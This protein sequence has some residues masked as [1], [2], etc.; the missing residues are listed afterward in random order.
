MGRSASDRRPSA[1]L[2]RHRHGGEPDRHATGKSSRSLRDIA[3]IVS[4]CWSS[5]PPASI[6]ERYRAL[7]RR[8]LLLTLSPLATTTG[9]TAPSCDRRRSAGRIDVAIVGGSIIGVA[10]ALTLA[11]TQRFASHCSRRGIIAGEQSSRNWGWVRVNGRDR[12]IPLMLRASELWES[13]DE[14]VGG[15]TGYRRCGIVYRGA[16]AP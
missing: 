8:G 15:D 11:R 14:R 13:M 7:D 6:A 9:P 5:P 1:E 12:E 3:R 2:C 4:S 10:A 16:H